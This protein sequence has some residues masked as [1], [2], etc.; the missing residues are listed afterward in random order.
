MPKVP[1][2]ANGGAAAAAATPAPEECDFAREAAA[3][4]AVAGT[5]AGAAGMPNW[6][7]RR[8][9]WTTWAAS[10]RPSD[11]ARAASMYWQRMTSAPVPPDH[12]DCGVRQVARPD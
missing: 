10:A 7:Q 12:K 4:Y 5:P 8:S 11:H 9:T 3:A 1:R 2:L 6:Q